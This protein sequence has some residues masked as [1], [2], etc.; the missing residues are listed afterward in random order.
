MAMRFICV[1]APRAPRSHPAVPRPETDGV[2]HRQT[3]PAL[4]SA[5]GSIFFPRTFLGRPERALPPQCAFFGT[6]RAVKGSKPVRR[7]G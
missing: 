5:A 7:S 3:H 4:K 6:H 2:K 1:R